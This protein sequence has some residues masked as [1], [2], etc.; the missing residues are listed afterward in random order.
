MYNKQ[1]FQSVPT[2]SLVI[3]PSELRL[4]LLMELVQTP[5]K[6][7]NILV[8][9]KTGAYVL[10]VVRTYDL[11]ENSERTIAFVIF[12]IGIGQHKLAELGSL[13]SSELSLPNDKAQKIATEIERDLFA[14][15]ALE[16]NQYL[17]QKKQAKVGPPPEATKQAP[18]LIDLRQNNFKPPV[19]PPWK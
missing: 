14:P 10:G 8:S 17:A 6:V 3:M 13:L 2:G 19:P 9:P 5:P 12:R 18:N 1:E 4:P 16:F 7:K 11:P 15:I